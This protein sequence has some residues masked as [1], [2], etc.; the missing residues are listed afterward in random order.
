MSKY[1][2]K[3]GASRLALGRVATNLH[4]VKNA[5]KCNEAN[6]THKKNTTKNKK[7][8]NTKAPNNQKPSILQTNNPRR[9]K[10]VR[11]A[12]TEFKGGRG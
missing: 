8:Q 1:C 4:F 5:I 11:S 3:N 7:P 2:W 9:H 12:C 10:K 6:Y